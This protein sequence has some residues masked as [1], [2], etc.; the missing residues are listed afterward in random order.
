MP[1]DG[2]S[3]FEAGFL[4]VMLFGM[5]KVGK[6]LHFAA[7]LMVALGTFISAFWILS[8]NSWMQ[9]PV[10]YEMGATGQ[11]LP[12]PSWWDIVFNPSFLA[13]PTRSSL[14]ISPPPWWSMG[15]VPGTC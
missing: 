9:R 7:T 11:F 6:K 3:E 13:W 12:G 2:R 10:G 15:S 14:P 8:V 5:N 1:A 4:G